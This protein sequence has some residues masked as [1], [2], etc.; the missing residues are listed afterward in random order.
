MAAKR[1]PELA[2]ITGATSAA[3]DQLVIFDTTENKT[4]R[5][6]RSELA[7]GVVGDLP[8]TPTGFVASNTLQGAVTEIVNDLASANG[9]A[10]VG[11]NPAGDIAAV[12]VQSALDELDTEKQPRNAGLT[13]IS[14]LAKTDGNVIVGN[15]TNWVAESGATARTS[16]GLGTGD[17]PQFTAIELGAATDTTLTRT[18]AGRIAVEGDTVLQAI[19]IGNTVQAYDA[20]T[21]KYDDTTANFTGTLQNG[22]S[23]VLVDTDIGSTIQA[24]DADTAKYD[25]ATANF[26]G[27][28]QN[29]GSNVL[30]DTDIGS[31]V[32]AYDADTAKYDDTT[33]NFTGTLQNGGSNVVVDSDIGS[34]VQAYDA[35]TAKYDDATANFTG[36]L[37][38]GGSNV[39][40]D[41]DIGSTVQAY[42]ADTAKLDVAQ[43]WTAKQ[44]FGAAAASSFELLSGGITTE[45]GTTRTL[46][47][48]DNGKVIYCTS[49]SAVTITCATG[50]GA[51][52]SCTIVQGGD[53]KVTIAAGAATLVSYSSLFSTM[54][55]YA[56]VSLISP[57]ADT[58]LAAG[59]L[60]V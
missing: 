56:V 13:D 24:Y 21:A 46:A 42:D 32:Q 60:G 34:T 50:L 38:N 9:A 7:V 41:T 39:V 37:Q 36:T 27:T 48:G 45:A 49:G 10:V 54:G 23:N 28:L 17:S 4:R 35:D 40:V 20:D 53:G 59:N 19:D 8:F 1:I 55:K 30:V 57:V 16:L 29:G 11:Y 18:S 43:T 51:G 3:D 2:A 15:G 22:G 33:A 5:I 12:S 52:F 14:G 47:A 44:T 31:T 25:D 6:L 26:T 58:F